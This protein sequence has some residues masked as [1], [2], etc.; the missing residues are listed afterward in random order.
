MPAKNKLPRFTVENARIIF[1]NFSG[2]ATRFKPAG[3]RSFALVL[4]DPDL[5]KQ[6]EK[7]G[8]NVKF[9]KPRD[10]EDEPQP[11]LNVTVAY[12]NVPPKI[13]LVTAHGKNVL[14]EE[15]VGML[16]YAEISNVD[17]IISPYEWEV[18]GKT[19]VSAY[20]KTMYVT[21]IEDELEQK[22]WNEGE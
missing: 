7:D 17:V 6:L 5:A 12:E 11:Y 18:G 2:A 13:V 22:Y 9:L 3:S 15:T 16:D 8:W 4:D 14:S 10:E 1:R 19:G 20:L 21:I